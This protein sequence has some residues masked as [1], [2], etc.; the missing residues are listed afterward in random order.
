MKKTTLNLINSFILLTQLFIFVPTI[1]STAEPSDLPKTY[2]YNFQLPIYESYLK[3]ILPHAEPLADIPESIKMLMRNPGSST[4]ARQATHTTIITTLRDLIK[5]GSSDEINYFSKLLYTEA[6]LI[7]DYMSF[8]QSHV[9]ISENI[10][11]DRQITALLKDHLSTINSLDFFDG[12]YQKT[13]ETDLHL[14][15]FLPYQLYR[16]NNTCFLYFPR[17]VIKQKNP[18]SSEINPIFLAYLRQLKAENK[19]HLYVNLTKRIRSEREDILAIENVANSEEFKNTFFLVTLFRDGDFYWQ[20]GEWVD[21]SD[22]TEFKSR[23]KE[24]FF[25]TNCCNWPACIKDLNWEET[26]STIVEKVHLDYFDNTSELTLEQRDGY[27]EL[28]SL[29]VIEELRNIIK[30]DYVNASCAYTMDRGP[31]FYS[32]EYVY[33]MLKNKSF[34]T[35][36][37]RK[38]LTIILAPP[39]IAH[40]R[41][42]HDYRI[43]RLATAIDLL[44]DHQER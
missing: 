12:K 10:I 38:F 22:A 29:F 18:D 3:Q 17:S 34:N 5:N 43:D 27:V 35:E 30:P 24:T 39:L 37:K 4:E 42:S 31:G 1:A 15:G 21:K 33:E 14:H 40:L 2:H 36:A 41:P 44:L 28:A 8:L 23:L 13:D 11:H 20:D 9:D 26:V 32:L 19:K 7:N 25:D 16:S 6:D